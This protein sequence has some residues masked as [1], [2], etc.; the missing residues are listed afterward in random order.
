MT[1][2]GVTAHF[3]SYTFIVPIIDDIGLDDASAALV[4]IGYG[5]AGLVALAAAARTM[6]RRRRATLVGGLGVFCLSVFLLGAISALPLD[7]VAT[8]MGVSAIVVWGA[9]AAVLPPILQSAAIRTSPDGAE[10]A[11]ALYVTA[12]QGGILSGSLVGSVTYDHLGV[13]AILLTTAALVAVTLVGV[14]VRGDAFR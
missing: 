5:V 1:L 14:L 11:S 9:S 4:L 6:D 2:I 8:F 7:A 13:T 10:Q 3:V 12:F